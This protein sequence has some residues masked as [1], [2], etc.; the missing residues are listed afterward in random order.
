[1]DS[2]STAVRLTEISV[3]F[4]LTYWTETE[5]NSIRAITETSVEPNQNRTDEKY[6]KNIGLFQFL[7]GLIFIDSELSTNF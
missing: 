4:R 5:P 7:F 6:K 1:M 3:S 2:W